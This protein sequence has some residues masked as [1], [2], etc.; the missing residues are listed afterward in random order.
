MTLTI[1]IAVA[2]FMVLI[3]LHE[4][5]HFLLAKKFDVRVDE[6]G[7]FIPP[8]LWGKKIGEI[9]TQ[10]KFHTPLTH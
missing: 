8:R 10:K 1:I 5:G 9:A 2:S 6:F 4:L 3:I 7:I